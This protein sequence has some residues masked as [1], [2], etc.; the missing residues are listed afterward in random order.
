[1]ALNP[2]TVQAL[3]ERLAQEEA[4]HA[5]A[6]ARRVEIAG[7]LVAQESII[8]IHAANI[9]AYRADLPAQDEGSE[10]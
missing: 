5:S 2:V 6:I 1:M 8:A 10:Q 3:Q 7:D 9:A 4:A